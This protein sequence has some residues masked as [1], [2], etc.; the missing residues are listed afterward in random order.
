M[1]DLKVTSGDLA[2]VVDEAYRKEVARW[3]EPP[4]AVLLQELTSMCRSHVDAE[5]A[6]VRPTPRGKP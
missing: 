4:T 5:K 6:K 2:S 3:A 1:A